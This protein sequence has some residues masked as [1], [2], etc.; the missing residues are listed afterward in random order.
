MEVCLY[1]LDTESHAIR[2]I[3]KMLRGFKIEVQF[4]GRFG[5]YG[6]VGVR[7]WTEDNYSVYSKII[8]SPVSE[9]DAMKFVDQAICVIHNGDWRVD[10]P[11]NPMT[12][13]DLWV[14]PII[15]RY[16]SR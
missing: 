1:E 8:F 14:D 4:N 15:W 2:Y 5:M 16:M 3:R 12:N 6:G 11:N 9:K 7:V 13:G 10:Y